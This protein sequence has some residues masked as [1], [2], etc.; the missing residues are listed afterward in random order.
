MN[1]PLVSVVILNWNGKKYIHQCIESVLKQTYLNIEVVFVDNNSTDTSL[2]ECKKLYP[3]FVYVLNEDNFGYAKGMNIGIN[4]S[5][6][7]CVLLLNTD[8]SLE[9]SYIEKCVEVLY[10]NNNLGCVAGIEYV[11]DKGTFSDQKAFC[12]TYGISYH[13]Q[14]S[15]NNTIHTPAFGVSGSFPIYKMSVIQDVIQSTGN[16]FDEYFETG[17]EDN[18]L[19]FLIFLLGW[20]TLC[21]TDT[22]AWHVGSASANEQKSLYCK[23]KEYQT[24]IFRNRFFVQHKYIKGTYHIWYFY[25]MIVNMILP[26]YFLFFHPRSFSPFVNGYKNYKHKIKELN[27]KRE[28]IEIAKRVPKQSIYKYI[29]GL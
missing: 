24:R 7:D 16:F 8:V 18:D 3:H 21:V 17:W 14:I 9:S 5:K 13:L 20:E 10:L 22:K 29:I 1:I 11:W 12:G 2:E 27:Q 23:D 4:K 25:L 28:M 26:F 19:R 6:G 15:S